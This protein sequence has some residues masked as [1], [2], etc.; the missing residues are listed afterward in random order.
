MYPRPIDRKSNAIYTRC[1]TALPTHCGL[2]VSNLANRASLVPA[3]FKGA[4]VCLLTDER[5]ASLRSHIGP[6]PKV[7]NF[8]LH[9]FTESPTTTDSLCSLT[10]DSLSAS[11]TSGADTRRSRGRR[12]PFKFYSGPYLTL[13]CLRG[14]QPTKKAT[15]CRGRFMFQPNAHPQCNKVTK[16]SGVI[17]HFTGSLRP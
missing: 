2:V 15:P 12:T 3:N 11:L 17:I 1:A 6:G 14:E 9:S 7:N 5:H 8:A 4:R 16:T 13:S 10:Y